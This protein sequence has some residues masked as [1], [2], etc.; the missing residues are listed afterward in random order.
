MSVSMNQITEIPTISLNKSSPAPA[1]P[2][3][4]PHHKSPPPPPPPPFFNG[5]NIDINPKIVMIIIGIIILYFVFSFFSNSNSS[6]SST[7]TNSSANN[8]KSMQF[9]GILF[10]GIL[11][12]LLVI[13][14][15]QYLLGINI[16]ASI[17]NIFTGKPEIDISTTSQIPPVPEI[18]IAKQVFHIPD[19]KYNYNDAKA[20]CKAYGGRLA[21]YKDIE[22]AYDKGADWCGYGWS[23]DQ[24]ALFPTQYAKWEK[25]Q[26]IDGHEN[27]CGRP[28]INGG[29]IDN[30]NVKFG[31]N[32]FG[33][34]PK[35]TPE[36]AQLMS[37]STLYPK[38][39]EEIDFDKSVNYWRNQLSEILVSPFNNNNWSVI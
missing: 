36:E 26:T 16:I 5:N 15:T 30:P 34:K 28:G 33:Y 12:L 1:P 4:P 13:N 21:N 9:L 25:L 10:W 17:K 32:C 11:I 22:K 35:I 18:E 2:P 29:F 27:D 38:T 37:E 24:M 19:N 6:Y 14:G 3:P 7:N 39:Q 8:E 20:I 23:D 31:I